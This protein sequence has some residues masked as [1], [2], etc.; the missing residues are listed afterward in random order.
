MNSIQTD[1]SNLSLIEK[2]GERIQNIVDNGVGSDLFSMFASDDLEDFSQIKGV[3]FQR[4]A[5]AQISD[6]ARVSPDY[7]V[8][9]DVAAVKFPGIVGSIAVLDGVNNSMIAA[10]EDRKA[11]DF[12]SMNS[13]SS[14][15]SVSGRGYPSSA[16]RRKLNLI[17]GSSSALQGY[18][19][20]PEDCFSFGDSDVENFRGIVDIEYQRFAASLISES[21]H[22]APDYKVAFES[23]AAKYPGLLDKVVELNGVNN[24]MMA[25]KDARKA[26]QFAISNSFGAAVGVAQTK[27][28]SFIASCYAQYDGPIIGVTEHHVVQSLG[29]SAVIHS[30]ADLDKVPAMGDSAMIKYRDGKGVVSVEAEKSSKD[31]G[32]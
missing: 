9:L 12:N 21:F 27:P 13:D 32:R 28:K 26:I 31:M 11:A 20:N 19:N 5:A 3:D 18:K 15:A 10:K 30:S 25:E 1:E 29:R 8:A 17:E 7:K 24:A 6:N 22:E 4:F 23:A 14:V 2:R 16:D